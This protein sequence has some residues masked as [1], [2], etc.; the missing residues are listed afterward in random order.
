MKVVLTESHKQ[1]LV[2]LYSF[3]ENWLC[4]PQECLLKSTPVSGPGS[5]ERASIWET[6]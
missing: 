2:A 5:L 4:G 1:K 6:L 3:E